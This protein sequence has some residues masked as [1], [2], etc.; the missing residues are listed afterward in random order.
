M[1]GTRTKVKIRCRRC[2]ERF[3]LKSKWE[4]GR[5]ETGFRQCVCDNDRD[6]DIEYEDY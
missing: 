4:K 5:V 3:V 2:G 1:A 6:F